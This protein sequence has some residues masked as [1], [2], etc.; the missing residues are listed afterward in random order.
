MSLGTIR[1]SLSLS[2][3]LLAAGCGGEPPQSN[4]PTTAKE[5]QLQEP[6]PKDAPKTTG[7]WSG[8]RYT[9]DRNECF[10]VVGKRCFKTQEAACAA[11]KCG[12]A[13]CEATGGG[14][15]SVACAK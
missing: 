13:K 9:G 14:P 11:A 12:A 10:F 1:L 4:E 8:W 3:V 7:Q 2:L 5:K 15:A 6:T